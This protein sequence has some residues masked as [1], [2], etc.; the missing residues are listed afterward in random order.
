MKCDSP[1]MEKLLLKSWVYTFEDWSLL[2]K[3]KRSPIA[4]DSL[5]LKSIRLKKYEYKMNKKIEW[6][7]LITFICIYMLLDLGWN[8]KD[9]LN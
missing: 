8:R 2:K 5:T 6:V 4:K 3:I 1:N 9:I 7:I